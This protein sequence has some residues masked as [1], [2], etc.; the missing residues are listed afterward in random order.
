MSSAHAG[1]QIPTGDSKALKITGW[2]TGIYF[3]IELAIGCW[4]GS[5][6]VILDAFHTF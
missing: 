4:S 2:L 3:F 5:V 6:A 1:H